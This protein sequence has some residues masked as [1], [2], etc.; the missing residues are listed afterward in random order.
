MFL[1]LR[2][3]LIPFI[4]ALLLISAGFTSST[5][6]QDLDRLLSAVEKLE[7]NLKALVDAEA[8]QRK[9][10]INDLRKEIK[11]NKSVQAG[12]PLVVD[13][14]QS[15]EVIAQM[16][17]DIAELRAELSRI[18]AGKTS[19][20]AASEV[21]MA[22][23][24]GEL[25]YLRG[26][27]KRLAGLSDQHSGQ[28]ATLEE[29]GYMPGGSDDSEKIQQL[30]EKL[31]SI[32]TALEGWLAK[33]DAGS[34]INSPEV[35]HGKIRIGG[36]LHQQYYQR[37]GTESGSSFSSK[38]A[39]LLLLG[40]LNE[41]AQILIQTDFATSPK[42][43]DAH[44][45]LTPVKGL[46]FTVGQL[47][48]PFSTD[49]MTSPS[50]LPLVQ[51][52]MTLGLAPGRD[53]GAMASYKFGIAPKANL[54]LS[55]GVFNGA[56]INTSDAN[57]DKNFIARAELDFLGMFTFA[58]NMDVGYD[59]GVD[60]VKQEL[61]AY[62][63]SLLWQWKNES[64]A[65]EVINSKLGD[66]ERRAWY[67]WGGHSFATHSKLLPVIQPV[68]RYEQYDPNSGIDTDRIDRLSIGTNFYIDQNYT[69]I[70]INYLINGEQGEE[71]KN[72]ELMMNFQVAF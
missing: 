56:G 58:P 17:K 63:G 16:Q 45:T 62:G 65:V 35:K 37:E 13:G 11:Q 32:N 55:A 52:A 44:F 9:E 39:R 68:M 10:A 47:I 31:T 40:P 14:G 34:S 22:T 54:K 48:V 71:I 15:G 50:A 69:K 51:N 19:A 66:I 24:M 25:E 64:A 46:S 5:M 12:Q 4:V 53:I 36:Y 3:A 43:L 1:Q 2:K 23:I 61:H 72:N 30:T 28:L 18:E 60:S 59:N 70:Q 42:L 21:D 27:V 67:I 8:Q 29:V 49:Y 33:S 6:A 7:A 38:R 26:E 57:E 41:Y 20:Q